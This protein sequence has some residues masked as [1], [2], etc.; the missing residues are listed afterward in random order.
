MRKPS[1]PN[2]VNN[3]IMK[4]NFYVMYIDIVKGY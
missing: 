3:I 2:Y 1:L 4:L